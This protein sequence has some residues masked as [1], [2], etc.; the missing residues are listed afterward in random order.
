MRVMVTG[1]TGFVGWAV[2]RTLLRGVLCREVE[3][4]VC[5]VRPSS[6]VSRLNDRRIR[7]VRGDLND[8]AS[9][10]RAMA[11]CDQVYHVAAFYSTHPGDEARM[12]RV[13]VEGTA[14]VL[15]AA[16]T[17]GV[18]RV[19]H[20]S[21]IGTIGRPANGALPCE[22]DQIVDL[23]RASA[24]ARSK[25]KAEGLAL[26]A[27]RQGLP[28]VV[29][30]PCAPVGIG[31]IAPSSTGQRLIAYMRGEAPSFLAGGINFCSVEDIAAGHLL[32]AERGRI[33]QRYILGHMAGNLQ[34]DDF[35][36]LM[37]CITGLA[38]PSV[39]RGNA[40]RRV[41]RA[42]ASKVH[43]QLASTG[44]GGFQ[45]AALTATPKLAIC[46]LGLPQTPLKVAFRQ[47]VIWF[48]QHGYV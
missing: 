20:T 30:N 3:E 38:P 6:D 39:E 42:L 5:L 43:G 7:L 34:R 16:R 17:T 14:N 37:Q 48:R 1:G 27:A 28:V 23:S 33:G 18:R 47:A 12:M 40:L 31:D 25:I 10:E 19:V 21:T 15:R 41:R 13:N 29:V 24:Y 26:E 36:A 35:Y 32:A 11:G 8:A 9:L 22:A 45:P 46:E 2:V 4:V 44:R